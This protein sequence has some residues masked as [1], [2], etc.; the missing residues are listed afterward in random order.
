VKPRTEAHRRL[1]DM[2][3][4]WSDF[5]GDAPHGSV[6]TIVENETISALYEAARALDPGTREQVSDFVASRLLPF[7][8]D[9]AAPPRWLP[10]QPTE[11]T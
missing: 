2:L 5:R 7:L 1:L 4:G 10:P 6:M 11:Q 8:L 3:A 9:A